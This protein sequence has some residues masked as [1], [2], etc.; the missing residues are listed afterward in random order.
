MYNDF[1][2]FQPANKFL[3]HIGIFAGNGKKK[4]ARENKNSKKVQKE[5]WKLRNYQYQVKLIVNNTALTKSQQFRLCPS[6]TNLIQP[7]PQLKINTP[8]IKLAKP[9]NKATLPQI[10]SAK[11]RTANPANGN[12]TFTTVIKTISVIITQGNYNSRL[13]KPIALSRYEI[14][15]TV[16]SSQGSI[17]LLFRENFNTHNFDY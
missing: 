8:Y 2:L 1:N 9:S 12:Y 17:S 16:S 10:F 5:L 7:N 11:T 15:E 3:P 14:S 6:R 4:P 13:S